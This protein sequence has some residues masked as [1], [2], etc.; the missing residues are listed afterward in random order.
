MSAVQDP[1]TNGREGGNRP[2]AA[3]SDAEFVQS[4]QQSFAVIVFSPRGDVQEANTLFCEVMGYSAADLDGLHHRA[5]CSPD[6]TSSDDYRAFWS[7]LRQGQHKAGTFHRFAKDGAVRWLTATY[8]PIFGHGGEVSKV[9]KI[10]MDVT[11][12]VT[13]QNERAA[14]LQAIDGTMASIEFTP[15]GRVLGCNQNFLDALGYDL[16]D[17]LGEH[18]R[19]FCSKE[20]VGSAE[21]QDLWRD[22]R[23][24]KAASGTYKRFGRGGREVWIRASYNPVLDVKGTVRKVVKYALDVTEDVLREADATA[25]LQALDRSQA[26]IEFNVDGI[27]QTA[28]DN[29]LNA[30]GYALEEIK[31]RHHRMFCDP[32]YASSAAYAALW[33]GLRAGR[34]EAGRFVRFGRGGKEIWIQASYNPIRNAEGEVVGVVKYATDIT[35]QVK[36]EQ[37]MQH[38][39]KEVD[40]GSTTFVDKTKGIVSRTTEVASQ[41]E[42]LGATSEEMS[43]NVEELSASIASIAASSGRADK[44]AR[45]ARGESETGTRAIE[46]A[47]EAMEEIARGSEEVADIV[48]VIGE[49]PIASLRGL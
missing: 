16:Q 33:E 28:N 34:L 44:L 40:S 49:I 5:F 35:Q 2:G 26:V 48:A 45:S 47:R 20:F 1:S 43:A 31:G 37:E 30:V 21:Y 11:E 7:D 3:A 38:L 10:A 15:E 14:R 46:Q 41:A 36:L 18:H 42:R 19:M 9:V 6:Y 25:R 17:V 4:L 8:T 32:E 13:A 12:Q 27:I 39:V 23:K 24:G 22:L 29:F